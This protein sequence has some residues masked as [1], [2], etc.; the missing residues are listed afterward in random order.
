MAPPLC[1][2]SAL[3]RHQLCPDPQDPVTLPLAVSPPLKLG[4]DLN[5]PPPQD[6]RGRYSQ[7]L[8]VQGQC[9][10][11][12]SEKKRQA[13]GQHCQAQTQPKVCGQWGRELSSPH[14]PR[15][16][17]V[18]GPG[19]A[20]RAPSGCIYVLGAGTEG[21]MPHGHNQGRSHLLGWWLQLLP[22]AHVNLGCIQ[23][24]LPLWLG[25]LGKEIHWVSPAWCQPP[26]QEDSHHHAAIVPRLPLP[27]SF[28]ALGMQVPP[29]SIPFVPSFP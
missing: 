18:L 17:M 20:W 14:R 13:V 25:T 15:L 12:P 27:A 3:T 6:S 21:C 23:G 7:L 10:T 2:S 4:T 16:V 24:P 8:L 22:N 29:C 28:P 5:I 9:E 19:G 26:C 1:P 11:P